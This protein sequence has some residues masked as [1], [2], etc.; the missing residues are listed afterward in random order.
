MPTPK[1]EMPNRSVRSYST[2]ALLLVILGGLG[3]PGWF[4]W[5]ATRGEIT[6]LP[7]R[8]GAEWILYPTAPDLPPRSRLELS[9]VFKR[10]FALD[11]VPASATLAVAGFHRY[12]L[13]INGRPAGARTRAGRNWKDPDEFDLAG[14]LRTGEN[15][16]SVTVFNTNGP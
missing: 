6:F 5:K 15:Q 16:V 14:F 4:W 2:W 12:A 13:E 1:L 10:S 11:Q 3:G 7:H 9:T 8:A